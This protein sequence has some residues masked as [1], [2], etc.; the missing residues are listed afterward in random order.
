MAPRSSAAYATSAWLAEV[1]LHRLEG[2]RIA[3]PDPVAQ[4]D[5]YAAAG[6]ALD[7][8]RLSTPDGGDQLELTDGDFRRLLAVRLGAAEEAD[9]SVIGSRLTAL[10]VAHR[11]DGGVL[12]ATDPV[13]RV[14]FEVRVTEKLVQSPATEFAFNAPGRVHRHNERA[15]GAH[16]RPRTP[17]RLGHIVIGTPDIDATKRFL[18]EG[19]GFRVSDE[20]PGIIAFLRCSTDHHNVALVGSE[21]A[22]LQHYSWECDDV[23]HVGHTGTKLLRRDPSAITWGFGRH[24]VGSNFFWYLPDPSG[25][26]CEFYSDMDVIDDDI[27]WETTG[28]SPVAPEL[29]GHSWGP[30]MPVEFIVPPDLD[31]LRAGWARIG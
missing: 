10:G 16:P 9:L 1:A 12:R 2:I 11:T 18:V 3:V 24:F 14:E 15:D 13:T 30:A 4:A 29:I 6:F 8:A 5:F 27:A 31:A 20:T 28:R 22:H 21:V 7:G 19:L 23:D 26:F 17:R 25:S